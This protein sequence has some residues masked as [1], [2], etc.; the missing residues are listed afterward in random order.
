MSDGK[1]KLHLRPLEYEHVF[2]FWTIN[3]LYPFDANGA[4]FDDEG[5]IR[6]DPRE[7][8]REYPHRF[9]IVWVWPNGTEVDEI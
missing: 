3:K 6:R 2:R 1:P 9:A 4:V 5:D 7:L 8:V